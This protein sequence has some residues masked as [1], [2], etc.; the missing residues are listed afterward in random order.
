M[1]IASHHGFKVG[2][3]GRRAT[4]LR[5]MIAVLAAATDAAAIVLISVGTGLLYHKALYGDSG[6]IP[7]F[8]QIGVVT[9]WLYVSINA[10]R[11][12]YSVL[13]YL[14]FKRYPEKIVRN[15]N[16]TFIGLIVLSFLT[17]TT[18]AHSRGWLIL[19][20]LSGF[21]ILTWSMRCSCARW[22]PE[23]KSV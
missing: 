11:L 16:I 10:Y 7:L 18:D 22:R 17:K 20:Y 6:P 13:S 19:F 4:F 15:W 1:S 8:V 23:T 3:A 21:L 2:V 12:E 5:L 9:A 14:E